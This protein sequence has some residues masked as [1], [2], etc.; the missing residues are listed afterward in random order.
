MTLVI[1]G[2]PQHFHIMQ[3]ALRQAKQCINSIDQVFVVWDD[4][5]PSSTVLDLE[6]AL[7][8][9]NIINMSSLPGTSNEP[10]G[11]LRQQYAKLNLWQQLN[12]PY[13]IVLDGDTILR[14]QKKFIVNDA[15]VIYG[16][17][18]EHYKP[19]FK[20][21][22][23]AIGLDKGESHSYMSPYWLCHR[24]VLCKI[25]EFVNTRHGTNLVSLFK[26]YYTQYPTESRSLSEVELYGL[27]AEKHLKYKLLFAEQNLKCCLSKDFLELWNTTNLDLCIGGADDL[28]QSFY[29]SHNILYNTTLAQELGYQNIYK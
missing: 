18:W 20:F 21:I 4:I 27:F 26:Q 17:P 8:G 7:P 29:Q 24:E 11:W 2:Y 13:W 28:P 16:D 1:F 10:Q 12:Q 15:T 3:L 6:Q 14:N 19:Y 9:C 25:H 23:H 5:F 22:N